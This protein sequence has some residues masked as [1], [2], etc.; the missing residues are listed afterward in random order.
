MGFEELRVAVPGGEIFATRRGEGPAAILLHGGPGVGAENIIGL[1]EEL[2]GLVG[3]P[4]AD[5]GMDGLGV[6]NDE[7]PLPRH[8]VGR[9]IPHPRGPTP[10]VIS[11]AAATAAAMA[12]AGREKGKSPGR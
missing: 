10:A 1:V 6:I 8:A 11:A 2:D 12:W 3:E 5:Q 9:R 7:D 4:G